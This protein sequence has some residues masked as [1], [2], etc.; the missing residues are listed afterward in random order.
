MHRDSRVTVG[1]VHE[2][3]STHEYV[4]FIFETVVVRTTDEILLVP[5][6]L[7]VVLC[8]TSV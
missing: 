1:E 8:Q 3:W 4:E 7:A 6:M 2:R 5:V